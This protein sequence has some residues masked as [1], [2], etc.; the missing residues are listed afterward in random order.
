MVGC[1]GVVNIVLPRSQLL[2]CNILTLNC[3]TCFLRTYR[4]SPGCHQTLAFRLTWIVC[5]ALQELRRR[6]TKLVTNKKLREAPRVI[7]P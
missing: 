1:T 4:L 3:D 5:P 6:S 2:Y 7:V